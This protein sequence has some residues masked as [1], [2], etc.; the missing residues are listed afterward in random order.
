MSRTLRPRKSRPSYV[1]LAGLQDEADGDR[2]PRA[3]PSIPR[4][5]AHAYDD[6]ADSGSNFEPEKDQDVQ[7]EQEEDA[8]GES[9]DDEDEGP[10]SDTQPP[11]AVRKASPTRKVKV[12]AKGA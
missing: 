12:V 8:M 1:A 10:E 6:D 11:K 9:I 2:S 5:Q 3:G 4:K 7:K